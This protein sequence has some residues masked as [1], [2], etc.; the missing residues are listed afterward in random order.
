MGVGVGVWVWV[1][2]FGC[3]CLGRV[4]AREQRFVECY[5]QP[6]LSPVFV[7][8]CVVRGWVG[9]S[10][11]AGLVWGWGVWAMWAMCGI[12]P[13]RGSLRGDD[14]Q[15]VRTKDEPQLVVARS[16]LHSLQ[17]PVLYLS[18][19]QRICPTRYLNLRSS[20]T[21]LQ[22]RGVQGHAHVMILD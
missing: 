12:P 1:W 9:A 3:G 15:I 7:R 22:L 6:S 18:R 5:N 17:Y 4:G 11:L 19:M 14:V 10:G 20:L 13:I 21:E 8:R 16:P 2:V